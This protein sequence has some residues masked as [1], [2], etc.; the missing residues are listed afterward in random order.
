[1]S[2]H[3][4]KLRGRDDRG[5]RIP[6]HPPAT[7][8]DVEPTR[9]SSRGGIAILGGSLLLVAAV[10]L[11]PVMV[12]LVLVGV[13]FVAL[14]IKAMLDRCT[15]YARAALKTLDRAQCPSCRYDLGGLASHPDGCI[16]CPECGAAWRADHIGR[17]GDA[18]RTTPA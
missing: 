17:V 7:A 13:L 10:V 4:I 15:G 11:L 8:P 18:A 12:T 5:Q 3:L 2:T 9:L 6:L 14:I 1:M 16:L